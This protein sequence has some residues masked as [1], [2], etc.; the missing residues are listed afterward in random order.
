MTALAGRSCCGPRA[1]RRPPPAARPGQPGL[2]VAFMSPMLWSQHQQNKLPGHCKPRH[3]QC[4]LPRQ[5]R[6]NVRLW[7]RGAPEFDLPDG[8]SA[9]PLKVVGAGDF[10][11]VLRPNVRPG[12]DGSYRKSRLG[13][14]EWVTRNLVRFNPRSRLTCEG[15]APA[16]A[17]PDTV[18]VGYP[19]P[20]LCWGAEDG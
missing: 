13:I 17:T 4:W 18:H 7:G 12:I 15:A 6:P 19:Q 3:S 8:Q 2:I 14:T 5:V 11:V 1:S 20:I 16:G 10:P 9:P